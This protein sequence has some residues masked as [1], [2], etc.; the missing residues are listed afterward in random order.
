MLKTTVGQVLWCP[1]LSRAIAQILY[2][3]GIQK[4]LSNGHIGAQLLH[5]LACKGGSQNTSILN[6]IQ[7]KTKSKRHTNVMEDSRKIRVGTTLGWQ[8]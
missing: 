8:A 2:W 6:R 7:Y 1:N 4:R 5:R 3:K